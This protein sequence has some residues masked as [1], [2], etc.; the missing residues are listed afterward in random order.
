MVKEPN[1][2]PNTD[3]EE[4]RIREL[5]AKMKMEEN[6]REWNEMKARDAPK[7]RYAKNTRRDC[8]F[9]KKSM[10]DVVVTANE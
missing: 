9:P 5:I 7:K 3:F 4:Q 2:I 8:E 10:H 6:L 1:R